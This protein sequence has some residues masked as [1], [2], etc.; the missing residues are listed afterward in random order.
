MLKQV[1]GVSIFHHPWK[2]SVLHLLWMSLLKGSGAVSDIS[3]QCVSGS[4]QHVRG[5]RGS[6]RR[7]TVKA[8]PSRGGRGIRGRRC[9]STRLSI[10]AAVVAVL[11]ELAK[12]LMGSFSTRCR[13]ANRPRSIEHL[14]HRL[15]INLGHWPKHADRKG[16]CSS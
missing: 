14:Q 7:V 10:Q 6:G 15:N 2:T 5:G 11:L 3:Q 9:V 12:Q 4:R 8:R 1:K 16:N 13:S